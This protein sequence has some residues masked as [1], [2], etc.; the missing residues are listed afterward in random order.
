L[1]LKRNG[2]T[3]DL[4]YDPIAHKYHLNEQ[5]WLLRLKDQ[6]QRVRQFARADRIDSK[7]NSSFNLINGRD[8]AP[9]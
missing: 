1:G 3:N 4:P 5:G 7:N 8:R 2:C 6:E 9:V